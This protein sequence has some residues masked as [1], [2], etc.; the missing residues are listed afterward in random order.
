MRY[1]S[2]YVE[3]ILIVFF[4]NDQFMRNYDQFSC[5]IFVNYLNKYKVL[6]KKYELTYKFWT[7]GVNF[8]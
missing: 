1:T 6:L 4:A 5:V 2:V 8:A 7:N 3:I